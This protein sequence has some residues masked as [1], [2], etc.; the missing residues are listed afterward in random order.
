MIVEGARFNKMDKNFANKINE[1]KIK[2]DI[3]LIIDEITS[4]WRS[5]NGGVYKF[6]KLNP[7]IVV[8]GKSIGNGYP[9]SILVGKAKVMD[10]AQDTFISSS[11]WTE[12]TGFAAAIKT[13]DIFKSKNVS[14]FLYKQGIYIEKKWYEI[15]SKTNINIVTNNFKPLITFKFKDFKDSDSS[16]SIFYSRNAKGRFFSN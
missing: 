5:R 13:I 11:L 2:K 1:I 9:I 4:G 14:K 6:S 10:Y 16:T 7:D 8:Y 3:I 12:S 15:A